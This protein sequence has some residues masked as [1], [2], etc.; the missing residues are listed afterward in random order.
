MSWI[1]K[2]SRTHEIVCI[3]PTLNERPTIAEVVS[4]AGRLVDRVVVVDGNSEDET[5]KIAFEAGAEVILQDGKGKGMA[6]KT[7]FDKIDSDIYVI[8]DGDATYNP[9]EM[10]RLITPIL[11]GEADMVV[12]SRLNGKMEE[13]AITST[14]RMGN[15][16]FNFLINLFFNAEIS[17]SQ[18]GYRAMSRAVVESLDLSSKGFEVETEITLDALKQKFRIKEIP[19][20]YTRRRGAASKL[21]SFRAGSKILRV[22]ICSSLRSNAH[23][24][25]KRNLEKEV[26]KN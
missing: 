17:D 19:I 8:I 7:V 18:S 16:F 12:G 6:L 20:T 24:W 25:K 1:S 15:D 3:I 2:G 26:V 11:E 14:N 22:I 21:N 10:D 23:V 13:G 9:L 5:S 4:K